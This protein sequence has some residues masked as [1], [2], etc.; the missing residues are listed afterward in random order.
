MS[1][2]THYPHVPRQLFEEENLLA[3]LDRM[4]ITRSI[5]GI[6]ALL[7]IVWLAEAFDIGI[8]GTVITQVKDLWH[9]SKSQVGFLGVSS[10]LGV[11]IGLIPSGI[12]ADKYGRKRVMVTGLIVFSILTL[13]G[14]LA[15]GF[16]S[17]CAIRFLAGIG[18]GTV[19]PAPYL[20]LSEFIQS[21]RRAVTIGYSNGILTAAYLL[22][23]LAGL[24]AFHAFPESVAWRIPFIM[25]G[26]PLL[27]VIP[28]AIW[29][30]SSPR[31]MLKQGKQAEVRRLVERLEDEAGLP[32]DKTLVNYRALA[33][34][35][36]GLRRKT[37]LGALMRQ[38]YLGRALL[39]AP[40]L[41]AALI[42]FYILLVYGPT[43]LTTR[44]FATG[45]AILATALMMGVGGI[46][47]VV[48]GYLSDAFGRRRILATYFLLAA[49]GCLMFAVFSSSAL[50]FIAAMLT[51]FFGL[52]VFPVSKLSVAEQYPTRLR[53]EGV[54]LCE[55]AARVVSGIVTIYFIPF[56]LGAWGNQVIFLGIALAILVFTLPFSLWGR[57][58]AGISVEE[59]GTDVALDN[60]P[61]G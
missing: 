26:I 14:A 25:G 17:L 7:S 28:L 36:Q 45:N 13:A 6:I 24:W 54:Y 55:M 3:R 40:Q 60:L 34:I 48:Q 41:C 30:P 1:K 42:L 56:I 59:A 20:Y 9:L 10:T 33:A 21:K 47:S 53:G 52:G 32:H 44:G 11:V 43:I 2:A 61:Q 39:V 37:G 15:H 19:I 16:W 27:L 29:L 38:P 50:V 35:E 51:A 5:V 18:E 57:E 23:N 4:P 8:V 12:I 49:L 58:T 46:G 31:L 22:P